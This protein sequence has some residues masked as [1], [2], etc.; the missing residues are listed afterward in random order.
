MPAKLIN[1]TNITGNI[2]EL[3]TG[4]NQASGGVLIASILF[5]I[6][7]V[8]FMVFRQHGTKVAL[9]GVSFIMIILSTYAWFMEWIAWYIIGIPITAFVL[10]LILLR[11]MD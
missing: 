7:F 5:L 9:T 11:V 10:S 2:V 1:T 6:Y 8:L 3:T 4:L